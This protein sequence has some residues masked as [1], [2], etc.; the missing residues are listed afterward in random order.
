M[1]I[2]Y[3]AN[4]RMPNE[5]AYGIQLAKMCEAFI[6]AGIPLELIVPDFRGPSK[7]SI[8]EFYG[9]RVPV[10]TTH[11]SVPDFGDSALGFNLRALVFAFKSFWYLRGK[12]SSK[13]SVI[14]TI[15]LDQFSFFLLPLAGRRVYIEIH[16]SK[17][18]NF[19]NAFFFKRVSGIIAIGEAV[20][21]S[22]VAAYS[23]P[24]TPSMVFPNGIDP[25]SFTPFPKTEAREKLGLP[26][27][28]RIFLYS[29]R[30]YGWKGLDIIPDAA[31]AVPEVLVYLVGGSAEEFKKATG[32]TALPHNLICA[33]LQDF[34]DMPL[35]LSAAD[36]F[37]LTGTRKDPYSY[38]ETSPMK[39]LE[40][41]AVGRPIIAAKTPAF[42]ALVSELDVVFYEPDNAGNLAE[43]MNRAIVEEVPFQD[44][45]RR[46]SERVQEFSW[47]CRAQAISNF[48]L[49]KA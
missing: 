44:M 23:I 5:R 46:M 47:T 41:G 36:F 6:E 7:Q 25:D 11:L 8:K 3:I 30:F 39:L 34:K 10:P 28:K 37:L 16:G 21:K 14:Y 4:A 2:Y 40:Y 42:T 12:D 38:T 27:H 33:G 19:L 24:N 18:K 48:I 13:D 49:K 15:D 9:L 35:W 43:M 32:V 1:K 20:K 26:L 22:I 17:H 29:G 31:R 45:M